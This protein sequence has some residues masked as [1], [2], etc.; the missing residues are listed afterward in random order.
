MSRSVALEVRCPLSWCQR[1][2]GERCVGHEFSRW[3]HKP[4]LALAY[5]H[6][7]RFLSGT[8][9]QQLARAE[10]DIGAEA[11]AAYAPATRTAAARGVHTDGAP[12]V[13]DAPDCGDC[14]GRGRLPYPAEE[15]AQT[16]TCESCGGTG[17]GPRCG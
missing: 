1:A 15:H 11:L 5:F 7:G 17:E 10:Q 4:R 8:M 14:G 3:S 6:T 13:P 12:F 9:R 2:R 16:R